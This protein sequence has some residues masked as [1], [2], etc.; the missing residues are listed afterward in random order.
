MTNIH[1]K[2]WSGGGKKK[3]FDYA[4]KFCFYHSKKKL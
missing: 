3:I 2:T 4:E 1:Y